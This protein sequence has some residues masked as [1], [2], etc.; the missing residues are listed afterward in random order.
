MTMFK[1]W[2]ICAQAGNKSAGSY[3]TDIGVPG[4]TGFIPICKSLPVDAKAFLGHHT[5]QVC[6]FSQQRFEDEAVRDER[7]KSM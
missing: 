3:R 2:L 5:P 1:A 6:S 7:Q 4:Y